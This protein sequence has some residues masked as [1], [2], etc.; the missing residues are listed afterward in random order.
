ML[1]PQEIVDLIVDESA[2]QS[3]SQLTT[4]SLVCHS[5]HSRARTRLFSHIDL[6]VGCDRSYDRRASKLVR[7]LKYKKNSDLISQRIRSVKVFLDRFLCCTQGGWSSSAHFP[8]PTLL[9][10]LMGIN[11]N[12]IVAALTMLK[13]APIEKFVLEGLDAYGTFPDD[14]ATDKIPTLLL[15]MCSNP[16]LKTLGFENICDLP[17]T[18]IMGR[19]NTRS[20]TRLVLRDVKLSYVGLKTPG[21]RTVIPTI[22][23]IETL[24]LAQMSSYD[25]LTAL[26][27]LFPRLPSSLSL[28]VYFK[29]L[30][31]L[32]VV[33]RCFE[34][35]EELWKFILGVADTLE[36]LELHLNTPF[37]DSGKF[38][39]HLAKKGLEHADTSPE[40]NTPII[41][42]ILLDPLRFLRRLKIV[43]S[44]YWRDARAFRSDLALMRMV[45]ASSTSPVH[46]R[47]VIL[48]TSFSVPQGQGQEDMSSSIL[49]SHEWLPIDA[50]LSGPNF[51]NLL[52]VEVRVTKV[53]GYLTSPSKTRTC[54]SPNHMGEEIDFTALLPTISSH[55]RVL[56]MTST[57]LAVDD[58]FN[59]LLI[60]LVDNLSIFGR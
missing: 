38:S 60:S 29:N 13:N 53:K 24:E 57:T 52:T 54:T 56:L 5:F 20:F 46:I 59:L 31:N 30:K 4:C 11:T 7:I 37:P 42:P 10:S 27:C 26:R 17:Y 2:E 32:A 6:W 49:T 36:S 50:I 16:N 45:L 48:E 43:S 15:D 3:I 14:P 41:S 39:L 12:P 34:E 1:L 58:S 44:I 51:V 28:S 18:F 19:D 9:L 8:G 23:K 47:S 40:S 55:P 25:F 33:L 22:E 21:S 35:R